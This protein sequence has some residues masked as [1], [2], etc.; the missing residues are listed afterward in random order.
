MA[1]N[2]ITADTRITQLSMSAWLA[3]VRYGFLPGQTHCMTSVAPWLMVATGTRSAPKWL[4][5]RPWI[6]RCTS[7]TARHRIVSPIVRDTVTAVLLFR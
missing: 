4:S 7:Q 6:V 3:R 5:Q 2:R 1:Y